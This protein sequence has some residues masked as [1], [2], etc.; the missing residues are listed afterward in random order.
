VLRRK[1]E[2]KRNELAGSWNRL[3]NQELHNLYSLINIIMI[4]NSRRMRWAGHVSHTGEMRNAY[5]ILVGKPKEK[6]SLQGHRHR[7]E[8][9]IRLDLREVA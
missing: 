6:L 5:K 3:Y 7:W 4:S 1:F 2:H 8:D 9:N